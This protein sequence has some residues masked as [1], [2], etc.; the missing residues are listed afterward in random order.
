MFRFFSHQLNQP[1][2]EL[3]KLHPVII[4]G[5]LER[6][7]NEQVRPSALGEPLGHPDHRSDIPGRPNQLLDTLLS[8]SPATVLG[9][10]GPGTPTFNVPL[11]DTAI[12]S[13]VE[14]DPVTTIV[15]KGTRWQHL[16]YSYM[17]QNTRIVEV[18]K[19]VVQS[20]AN[21]E[22][23]GLL[24]PA[25]QR[26][27][28][29]TEELFFRTPPSYSIGTVQ[30]LVRADMGATLDNAYHRLLGFTPNMAGDSQRP[31]FAIAEHSNADL[32]T[33]LDELL[34]EIWQGRT[35]FANSAGARPTDD[36]KI[37]DL[38][39][40]ICDM[41]RSRRDRGTLSR[42]EFAAAAMMSWFHAVISDPP[43]P[44]V[45]DL[46][47]QATSPEERL[48][49]IA[50]RVGYSA[51]GLSKS[52][53]EVAEPLSRLLIAIEQ[54]TFNNPNAVPALYTPTPGPANLLA[55][56]TDTIKTHWSIIRGRDVKARRVA[57]S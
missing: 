7:W 13:H 40:R 21:G 41:L 2:A 3:S 8:F 45:E 50:Q 17:I 11:L 26:W 36:A 12:R 51:H 57:A 54:G 38:C 10:A 20:F 56:D 6:C 25:S 22:K 32:V 1:I 52:Y 35:N 30:S 46:R 15:V 18:F 42:E 24:S 9:P 29:T 19:R 39:E 14:T 16:I 34:H 31:A 48:F 49:K 33:A 44:I 27:L 43:H 55:R 5:L 53:F 37:A 4:D 23:L 47:A 28:W